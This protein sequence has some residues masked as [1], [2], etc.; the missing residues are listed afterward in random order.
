MENDISQRERPGW[1]ALNSV[2][3]VLRAT[4]DMSILSIAQPCLKYL[5][6]WNLRLDKERMRST[7]A[8]AS[9]GKVDF[10]ILAKRS[11]IELEWKMLLRNTT[12]Q[13]YDGLVMLNS[14]KTVNGSVRL[15]S[16]TS[17]GRRNHSKDL[18]S[19]GEMI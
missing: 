2:K 13:S 1:K 8:T 5:H 12:T 17:E 14:S 6:M 9:H 3:D 4:P 16:G 19:G 7:Y 15:T 11:G 18:Q 10:E